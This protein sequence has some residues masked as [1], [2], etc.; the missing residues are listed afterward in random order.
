MIIPTDIV[1][2]PLVPFLIL[3][4]TA[5]AALLID[6]VLH[7]SRAGGPLAL[8]GLAAAGVVYATQL[9]AAHDAPTAVFGLQWVVDVPAVTLG[10]VITFGAFLS[11]LGGWDRIRR[12]GIDQPEYHPL[13]LLATAGALVMV[14]AGDFVILL[15]GLE[16]LSLAVYALAAWRSGNRA[17]EEA[18]MKYFLLGAFAS[19]VLV[20]GI[21]LL[22]GA[23]GT[24]DYGGVAAALVGGGGPLALAGGALVLAGLGFKV[25]FAPFH[26]WAPDVYTGAPTPVTTFMSVVVKAAAFGAL[27][28][29]FA[30]AW[31]GSLPGLELVLAVLVGATLLVGNF[32]ALLQ[33]GVKRMLGYSAVAHAGFLGLAVL[34]AGHD[35]RAEQALI[36]YLAA[37]TLMNAGAF[38]VLMHVMGDDDG[39][40]DRIEAFEG[41]G[42]TRPGLAIAMTIFL[43][44]LA[45][46][47]PLAGFV[48]K[49]LSIQVA[50]E[51][52]WT[53]L[54]VVAVVGA[55]VGV[56]YYVRPVYAMWFRGGR[57][58]VPALRGPARVAVLLAATGTVVL[59]LAPDLIYALLD[60]GRT[61]AL[62]GWTP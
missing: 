50:I 33:S 32:G 10:L 36:W 43:L 14:H 40:G 51:A 54:A 18:G 42:A 2:G 58:Q 28:R 61:L 31:P 16:I 30:S 23:T 6:V 37:Y 55:V 8:L 13:L 59:G 48:G 12:E 52:G 41:L 45:G 25:A 29:V 15:L 3:V 20:Y 21:A 11:V 5:A 53:G 62:S 60:G 56:V 35:L 7:R 24:F 47:P 17:S 4:V 19:A 39:R 38:V 34:A 46:I 49:L 27:L 9:A 22:Y 44:S 57:T 1:L 26:Q